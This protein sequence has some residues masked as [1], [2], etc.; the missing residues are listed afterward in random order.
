MSIQLAHGSVPSAGRSA[1]EESLPERHSSALS[2]A[3]RT[4]AIWRVRHR[5]RQVLWELA[6]D[7]RLLSDVGLTREQAH[8]EAGK[9]FWRR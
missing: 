7:E 2:A 9:P 4:L 8:R 3:R 6:Q 5:Q 1:G